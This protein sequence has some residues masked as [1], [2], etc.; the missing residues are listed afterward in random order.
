MSGGERRLR[1]AGAALLLVEGGVHLQQLLAFFF[2]VPWIGPMFAAN[3]VACAALAGALLAWRSPLV[4]LAGLL[5]SA[6]AIGALALSFTVGLLGW[7]EPGW[8][9]P[10]VVALAAEVGAV[11]VLGALLAL[12]LARPEPGERGRLAAGTLR[13]ALASTKR[14]A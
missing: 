4:P 11:L 13:A 8:R 6:G 14:R 7:Q 5:V 3:A 2:A 9:A 12:P 10:V 1:L